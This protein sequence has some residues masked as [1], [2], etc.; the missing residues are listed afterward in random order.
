MN[1]WSRGMMPNRPAFN[2]FRMQ[3]R[4]RQHQNYR[5]PYNFNQFN[6]SHVPSNERQAI[7][8]ELRQVDQRIQTLQ[9]EIFTLKRQIKIIRTTV[10]DK[11]QSPTHHNIAGPTEYQISQSTSLVQV[12]TEQTNDQTE[13][14]EK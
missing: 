11:K 10:I 7:L 6:S 8:W 9:M 12:E 5:N 3:P 1:G 13:I 4:K 14:I 2:M